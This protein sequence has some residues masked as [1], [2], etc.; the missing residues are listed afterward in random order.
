MGGEDFSAYLEQAPGAFFW[1][2]AGERGRR[3]RTITRASR[4]TRPPSAPAS[5][6]SSAPRSTTWPSSSHVGDAAL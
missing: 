3:S 6:S 4:S 1:V 2:G 5:P